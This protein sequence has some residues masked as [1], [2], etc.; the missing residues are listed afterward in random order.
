MTA[1]PAEF[2]VLPPDAV[3]DLNLHPATDTFPP[4][5]G[6]ALA[7]LATDIQA[8][9]LRKPVVRD[10][11][12]RVIDGR[13]RL[14]ACHAAGVEPRFMVH[15]GDPWRY[16]LEANPHRYVSRNHKALVAAALSMEGRCPI[17]GHQLESIIGIPAGALHRAKIVLKTGVPGLRDLV[18]TEQIPLSTGARIAGLPFSAQEEFVNRVNAGI[19]HRL[20]SPGQMPQLT[21]LPDTAP[22]TQ[23]EARYRYVQA[24]AMGAIANSLDAL[25]LVIASASYGLDPD[26]TP[27]QAAQW[28]SDLNRRAR[29]FRQLLNLL[30]ERSNDD[31]CNPDPQDV[32]AGDPVPE[33][34]TPQRDVRGDDPASR[35]ADGGPVGAKAPGQRPRRRNRR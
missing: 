20:A 32:G 13:A 17:S 5:A 1:A 30:K 25:G 14:L 9:G 22:R 2:E 29:A 16:V 19:P 4:V 24:P 34:G 26:I 28:R 31:S 8:N 27:V 21:A 11:H 23:R 7:Q 6:H 3:D 33:P 18:Q 10:A 12:G 15:N 35:P